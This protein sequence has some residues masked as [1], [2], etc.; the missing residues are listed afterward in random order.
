[1][2]E[3]I[4]KAIKWYG[5]IFFVLI[6]A[7]LLFKANEA[8]DILPVFPAVLCLSV[9]FVLSYLWRDLNSKII[10]ASLAYLVVTAF[11]AQPGYLPMLIYETAGYDVP[12]GYFWV[13]AF[14][15]FMPGIPLMAWMFKKFGD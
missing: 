13:W 1:M 3:S 14:V 15:V 10:F 8:D 4:F 5:V 9:A 2:G 6:G 11:L 7:R 12:Y